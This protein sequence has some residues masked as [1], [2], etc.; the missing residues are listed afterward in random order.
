VS[1]V[2]LYHGDCLDILPTLGRV[3]A[4]ITDP[5]YGINHKRGANAARPIT[6]A[7][8]RSISSTGKRF[9]RKIEGDNKPFDPAPFLHY[10][11]VAFTG[12]QHFYD[13]LPAGGSLHCW[14]KRGN[15][16]PLDQADADIIWI[17]R[18]T[19][20]RLL[21]LAWRGICR[22]AENRERILHPTQKPVALMEW[23]LDL[24]GVPEG[25]VV[26]DPYMGVA[27]TGIACL[28]TGRHF[29]GIEKEAEWYDVACKRIEQ[30]QMR[31]RQ[32]EF[33]V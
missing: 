3:D 6:H 22:H 27:S 16:K 19:P 11:I 32:L 17:S 18:P 26:V 14:D 5:P 21:H 30:A 12:A 8:K 7:G 9:T 25:A 1:S 2:E 10:P 13:R 28:N 33:A 15:Y 4:V 20:S 23:V 24:A 31:A 29:I